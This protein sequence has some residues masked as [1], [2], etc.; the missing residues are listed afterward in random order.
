MLF[1]DDAPD[2]AAFRA[3]VQC[4]LREALPGSYAHHLQCLDPKILRDWH[5]RMFERGWV[6]PNWP[7]EN[8]GMGASLDEYLVLLDELTR[9]GAP[10]LLPTGITLLGPVLIAYGTPQQKA[11]HLPRIL[12][13]ETF[14]A[15]GYSE[16][17]A[18]SD[19]AALS[20]RA[21]RGTDGAGDHFVVTGQK[22]WSSYAHIADWMF[23]LVR[24]NPDA[25]P[26]HAGLSMLL[27]DLRSPGVTI[28]P[29]RTIADQ[30]EFA[31]VDFADVRVP[32]ENLLGPEGGGWKVANHVL[33]WERLSNGSP[34]IALMTWRRVQAVAQASGRSEDPAFR[35][36]LAA[37]EIRLV[38]HLACYRDAVERVKR[39][40]PIDAIAP[41]LKIS[42]T[43]LAQRFTELLMI[44]AGEHG[45]ALVLEEGLARSVDVAR[46][47]LLTRRASIYGGSN[48]IQRNIVAARV[49]GFPKAW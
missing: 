29:L 14:W 1:G 27:I 43:E 23:A 48:E 5:R 10:Y 41:L 3:E 24:T 34:R 8:G 12:N 44:A 37:A 2:I 4:W 17:S 40:E 36:Q 7:R 38:A 39:D 33:V 15:Q 45:G 46:S 18:G 6:A 32:A 26:R 28:Q 22:L 9:A 11:L 30:D 16:A 35:D 47:F 25:A 13:G 49:L 20:T 21:V 19:L 31:M 42:S